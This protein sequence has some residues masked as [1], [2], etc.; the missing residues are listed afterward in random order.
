M[1]EWVVLLADAI[2]D[3]IDRIRNLVRSVPRDILTKSGAEHL[4]ARLP[5]ATGQS[6]DLLEHFIGDRNRRFHTPS[7]TGADDG[8]MPRRDRT[9]LAFH[10]MAREARALLDEVLQLPLDERAKMAAELLESLHEAEEDVER[11]WAAEIEK[12][13]AAARAGELASTDWRTVL[14]RVETEVLGR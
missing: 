12:R 14:D 9:V 6:F 7:I 10:A 3:F 11:A 8:E 13:V 2:T 1:D 4:T 5:R